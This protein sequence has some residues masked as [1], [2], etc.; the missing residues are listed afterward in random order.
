MTGYDIGSFQRIN[1]GCWPMELFLASSL[2]QLDGT[3]SSVN[4]AKKPAS[5]AIL[6]LMREIFIQLNNLDI[7]IYK[8]NLPGPENS[9]ANALS[10]LSWIGNSQIKSVLLNEAHQ[11]INFQPTLDAFA[12]KT[13]KQLKRHCLLQDD[14]NAIAR[15][16]LNIPWTSDQLLLHP[17]IGFI[18]KIIQKTIRDQVEALLI[19]PRWYLYKYRAKHPS[20]LN[21]ET[22]GSTDQVLI[23]GKT[24][25]E[26]TKLPPGII[27]MIKI[28]IKKESN[29]IEIIQNQQSWTQQQLY[30]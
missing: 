12:H 8:E 30:N 13:N 15:N 17:P 6:H 27:E 24:M 21:Q 2:K 19:L 20:I 18:P 5:L 3:S 29:Y 25:K 23:K 22:F 26:F 7:I 10:L 4:L 14:N 9:T 16:A 28:N 11:Q 1:N